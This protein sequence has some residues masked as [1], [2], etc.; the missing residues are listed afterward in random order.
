MEPMPPPKR[1]KATARSRAPGRAALPAERAFVVQLRADADPARG[2]VSGRVEHLVSGAAAL[3]ESVE[4][5]V[6]WIRDVIGR[7]RSS[8]GKVRRR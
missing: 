5:L 7:S 1:T 4:Q 6:D 8:S 3:F 2:A